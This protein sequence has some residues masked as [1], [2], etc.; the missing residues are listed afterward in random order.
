MMRLLLATLLLSA[1]VSAQPA[2]RSLQVPARSGQQAL[3]VEVRGGS[4]W[5]GSCAGGSCATSLDL[6]V[7]E[8]FRQGLGEAKLEVIEIGGRRSVVKAVVPDQTRELTWV[9]LVAGPLKPGAPMVLFAGEA[10]TTG[11]PTAPGKSLVQVIEEG[12]ERFVVVGQRDREV[13]LC[14]RPSV[15]GPRVVDPADLSWK[16]AKVQRLRREERTGA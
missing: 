10:D 6:G 8:K 13:H 14:G 11:A 2:P 12:G 7:P 3:T 15:L 1:G 16:P 9:T 4:L 5:A